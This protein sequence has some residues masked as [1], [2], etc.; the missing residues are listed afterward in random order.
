GRGRDVLRWWPHVAGDGD[1]AGG[2][3]LP[4]PGAAGVAPAGGRRGG[5]LCG[6]GGRAHRRPAEGRAPRGAARP[7]EGPG[8]ARHEDGRLK[9]T[10]VEATDR[11]L[12]VPL[13]VRGSLARPGVW[14]PAGLALMMTGLGLYALVAHSRDPF[15][16][17]MFFAL[18]GL[19]ALPALVLGA[20]H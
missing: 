13:L 16:A 7:P 8:G 5:V 6:A 3:L 1:A 17:R 19:F 9:A 11:P 14:V 20:W 10:G 15:L 4:R 12:T 2:Q 18:A